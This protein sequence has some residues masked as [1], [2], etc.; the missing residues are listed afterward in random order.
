MSCKF[1][2]LVLASLLLSLVA[3]KSTALCAAGGRSDFLSNLGQGISKKADER[4]DTRWTLADWFETKRQSRLQDMWL[5]GHKSDDLYEFYA[6]ART[7]VRTTST[8]GV[9]SSVRIRGN[10]ASAGAYATLVGLEGNYIDLKGTNETDNSFDGFGWDG[11]IG[12]RPLGDSLQNS[13][14]TVFYGIRF[15]DEF[16]G[17]TIQNKVAKARMTIYL[18]K[19]VGLE[20]YYQWVFKDTSNLGAEIDGSAFEAQGFL[21]FSLLRVYGAWSVENRNRLASGASQKTERRRE[22]IDAGFKLFF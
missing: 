1:Q 15:R 10:Q 6:G 8:D 9:E 18:T 5:A 12:F 14:V 3:F 17:E 19:A 13:N 20:G 11:L 22:S 7:G 2:F 4:Y 16:G 21:D